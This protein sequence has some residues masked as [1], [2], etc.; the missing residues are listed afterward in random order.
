MKRALI[1]GITGQD[2]WYLA[3]HLIEQGYE[4][5]G[6]TGPEM[7]LSPVVDAFKNRGVSVFVVDMRDRLALESTFSQAW[8][9]EVYNLAAQAFP[10][11]GWSNP[12]ETMAI[13]AGGFALLLEIVNRMK[14][15]TRVF[16]ASTAEMY[17]NYS[18]ACNEE[19]KFRPSSLYGISKLAAHV[20]CQMYR[21][22]GLYVV[23]GVLF[24]HESPRRA[25]NIVTQKLARAA[26]LWSLGDE[27]ILEIGALEAR[28]DWGYAPDY[29]RAMHLMLNQNIDSKAPSDYVIGSGTSHSV[30]DFLTKCCWHAGIANLPSH[31][32]KRNEKF[33][34]A[35]DATRNIFSNTE[36]IRN[37]LGWTPQTDFSGL[38]KIMVQSQIEKLTKASSS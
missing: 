15:S 29:V 17:G 22:M 3:D 38:C 2:G 35:S 23:A 31:L 7:S 8:P 11:M 4:V 5:I 36:R 24:N 1:T 30:G 26:A 34:R 13:N 37:E 20:M 25:G 19:N 32:I 21:D 18:G 12:A 6:T 27:S 16:Q 28:R 10:P 14:S 33:V 9:D